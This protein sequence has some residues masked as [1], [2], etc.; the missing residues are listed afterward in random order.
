MPSAPEFTDT[1]RHIRII[2]IFR[3]M[4]TEHLTQTDRHIRITGKIKIDL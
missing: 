4:E 3:E 1:L 2:E